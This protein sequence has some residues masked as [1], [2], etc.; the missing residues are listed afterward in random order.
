MAIALDGNKFPSDDFDRGNAM[1]TVII[2]FVAF[3]CVF[4]ALKILGSWFLPKHVAAGIGRG[5][6]QGFVGK[7]IVVAIGLGVIWAIGYLVLAH[8]R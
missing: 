2:L 7:L 4:A 8:F 5:V 1:L 3:A 6:D